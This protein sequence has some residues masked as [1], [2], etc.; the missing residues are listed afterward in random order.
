MTE[1]QVRKDVFTETRIVDT[2][3]VEL[4]EGQVRI[5]VERFGF[6][7]NNITYAAVGHRIGYWQFFPA[8]GDDA[9]E[10]GVI[11]VWGFGVVYRVK[12]G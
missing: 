12:I 5:A 6:S 3:E 1:F 11:P 7:A 10:W 4:G 2:Y 9:N 8:S